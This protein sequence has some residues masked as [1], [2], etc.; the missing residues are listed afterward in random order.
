MNIL[1]VAAHA[2]DETL[3]CGAT[4]ARHAADGDTVRVMSPFTDGV[5]SRV[6]DSDDA[7]VRYREWLA[8]IEALGV[9]RLGTA[10]S[11]GFPDQ[12]LDTVPML[13][14]AKTVEN[15]LRVFDPDVIYT[16]WHGDLNRDHQCVAEAV[17]VATRAAAGSTVGRVLAFEVPETT[18]QALGLGASFE[19][20][21][22]VDVSAQITTKIRALRCY[23]SERRLTPHLR[24]EQGVVTQAGARGGEAGVDFAEAF[25]LMRE[26]RR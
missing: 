1:C 6:T 23:A 7:T 11:Y 4:L 16:H 8:A 25:V 21:V 18:S 13:S 15:A 20:N 5:S 10:F 24:S 2:D 3:G 12:A 14:L 26:V 19:P 9:R 17:L 22:Y